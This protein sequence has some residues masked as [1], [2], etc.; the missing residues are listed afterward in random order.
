MYENGVYMKYALMFCS[1]TFFIT[2][3]QAQAGYNMNTM[4]SGNV[5]F[6][7]ITDNNG[8]SGNITTIQT[9]GI[10]Y[11]NGS[12]NQGHSVHCT[13]MDLGGGMN[14]TNCN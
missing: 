12:D 5:G 10:S 8:Y 9:P 3:S 2:I 14:T 7:N 1:F 13:S 11:S 4:N 6:T